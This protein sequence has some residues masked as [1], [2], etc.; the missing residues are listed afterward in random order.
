MR[1]AKRVHLDFRTVRDHIPD[2]TKL[3]SRK[4][5]RTTDTSPYKSV[6]TLSDGVVVLLP[7]SKPKHFT[8]S[9]IKKTIVDIRR[10]ETVGRFAEAAGSKD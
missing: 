8:P 4:T 7:K 10:D 1:R 5:D 2:M 6:G 3:G 9:Q